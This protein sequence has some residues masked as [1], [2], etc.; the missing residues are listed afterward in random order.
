MTVR[1]YQEV[2][3]KIIS[4]CKTNPQTCAKTVDVVFKN[5]VGDIDR[6]N[7]EKIITT[8]NQ[9]SSLNNKLNNP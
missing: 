5:D 4:G 8:L 9:P 7:I 3:A 2:L 1:S 6:P